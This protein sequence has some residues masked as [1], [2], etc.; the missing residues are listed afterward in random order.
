MSTKL[1]NRNLCI[2]C[3]PKG[4][5]NPTSVKKLIPKVRL[6]NISMSNI[7]NTKDLEIKLDI[8]DKIYKCKSL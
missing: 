2:S 3:S 6:S 8:I 5:K 4:L 7:L 1:S